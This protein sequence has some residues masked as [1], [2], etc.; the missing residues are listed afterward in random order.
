MITLRK[1]RGLTENNK[2]AKCGRLLDEA[3]IKLLRKEYYNSSYLKGICSIILD[4]NSALISE[5]AKNIATNI[6]DKEQLDYPLI[7]DLS[8]VLHTDLNLD[9][10]DWDIEYN[11]DDLRNRIT[12]P[13]GVVL[14]HLR[15]PFNVGSIFRSAD[16][17]GVNEIFLLSPGSSI[18]HPRAIRSA[19]GSEKVV[20]YK[21]VDEKELFGLLEGKN[22]FALET[23]GKSI[24]EFTFP[25]DGVVIIGNEELGVSPSLLELAEKS[26][27]RVT[28]DLYG[29]K[30]SLNVSVAFGILM[31]NWYTQVHS[32]GK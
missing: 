32:R 30:G 4:S 15:S 22:V 12:S 20:P 2:L 23:K 31:Y 18:E 21:N 26:L 27:G 29:S 17:F 1:L 3:S 6:I 10:A 24:K 25:S 7:R 28:I 5:Q 9:W 13:F 8:L 19:R 11:Q 14:D 16:S